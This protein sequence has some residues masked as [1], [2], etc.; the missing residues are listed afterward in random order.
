MS[1]IQV[2][3]LNIPGD[4][5]TEADVDFDFD[6][7]ANRGDMG[8]IRYMYGR[9]ISGDRTICS[10]EIPCYNNGLRKL[11]QCMMEEG[12]TMIYIYIYI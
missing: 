4:N 6:H 9:S 10:I 8:D 5:L 2:H 3:I 11:E 7:C 12:K 1:K